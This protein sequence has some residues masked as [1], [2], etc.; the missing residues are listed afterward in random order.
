MGYFSWAIRYVHAQ[1]IVSSLFSSVRFTYCDLICSFIHSVGGATLILSIAGFCWAI[2]Q[3]APFALASLFN[4]LI[5]AL[6]YHLHLDRRANPFIIRSASLY[7][8]R[9]RRR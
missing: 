7:P 4:F 3:W 1:Y 2:T 6:S 8:Q 5:R 9:Q